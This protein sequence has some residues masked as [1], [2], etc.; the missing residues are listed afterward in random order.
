[1]HERRGRVENDPMADLTHGDQVCRRLA[2]QMKLH[3]G[4]GTGEH[5]H[6]PQDSQ[7]TIS[8]SR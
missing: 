7:T 2:C 3:G 4:D 1:M 6:Q 8:E 5:V